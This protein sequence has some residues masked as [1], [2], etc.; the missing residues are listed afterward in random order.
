MINCNPETVSTD[1]DICDRLYFDEISFETVMEIYRLEQPSGIVLSMGGQL[2]NNIAIDL[3][4]QNARILGTSPVSIDKAEN[5]LKF[6]HLLDTIDIKQPPWVN[7]SSVE[8]AKKFCEEEGYPCVI[9]PSYVLSGAAMNVALTSQDLTRCLK[10]AKTVSQEFP[11]VVS[12][13]I[14]DAKEIDVDAICKDGELICMA[15]S[16]H[17]ENAGVHSG[18]A[19]LVCP[20]QDLNRETLI[21]IRKIAEAIGKELNVNGPYNMQLIAKDSQLKVI[22]C[23]LRVSR[24]FPFVSKTLNCDFVAIATRV[25]LGES[26]DSLKAHLADQ[27]LTQNIKALDIN[28][29][30]RVG[31]KVPQ[32]SF[33][34]LSG[35][36]VNLGVEMASTGEVACFGENRYEAYLKAMISTGFRIPIKKKVY[37][38]IGSYKHKQELM[39]SVRTLY[40]MGYE[41]YASLGTADYYNGH[42]IKIQPISSPFEDVEQEGE[43]EANESVVD[44]IADYLARMEFDLIINLPMRIYGGRRVSTLGYRTRRFAVDHSI[45]LISDV[46]CTKLL[47]T[48]LKLV[49]GTPAV[50]P[51]IDCL[52]SRKLIRL[53]GLIDIH[54]HLRVPGAEHKEDFA[55]GTA[56]ALAGGVTLV[57]AMPNTEPAIANESSLELVREIAKKQAKCDY[58]LYLGATPTNAAEL[59]KI[60]S[61]P[62]RNGVLGL[63][64]YLN[65]TFGNLRM[66]KMQDW[67]SHFEN[68]PKDMPLVCHAEGQ[69]TAAVI[70]FAQHYNRSVHI[71]HVAREEEIEIIKEAKETGIKVSCEACPHHLFLC[72]DDKQSIGESKSSVKPELCSKS[73]QDALWRNLNVIDCF[74]TDHAPHTLEEKLNGADAPPGFPGLETMLPLL[75]TAVNQG[76]LTLDEL[77]K[78]LYFNP[79]RI[80]NLPDQPNTY[81]EVDLDKEWKIGE[82]F[83]TYSKAGWT[84]FADRLVK[85]KVRRVVLRGEVA[86]IDGE[87][88]VKP[89]FGQEILMKNEKQINSSLKVKSNVNVFKE[90]AINTDSNKLLELPNGDYLQTLVSLSPNLA[91]S[92]NTNNNRMIDRSTLE[93]RSSSFSFDDRLQQQQQQHQTVTLAAAA[94]AANMLTPV[95][96]TSLNVS[97]SGNYLSV[98]KRK[99]DQLTHDMYNNM[100]SALNYS[101][102]VIDYHS[103]NENAFRQLINKNILNVQPFTRDILRNLF[104]L[105]STYKSYDEKGKAMDH[106]LRGKRIGSLFFE[107]STRTKCSFKAATRALGGQFNGLSLQTSSIS[108][109]ES[110]EDT[111][112]MMSNYNQLLIIRHDEPG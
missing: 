9:R 20:P 65:S 103:K 45:P 27:N 82:S 63:K 64:M 31:V 32:F 90:L 51:H 80:F 25:I 87:V 71:C 58:A 16:E 101:E 52:T 97:Q 109:G 100:L 110:F 15:I 86:F 54:V 24:S 13:F 36:D 66:S 88:L 7:A 106:I 98:T 14:V 95:L 77:I 105:A 33:S 69:T 99:E 35:A 60:V 47:I 44:R 83:K 6:S 92:N 111:V 112:T 73:D 37:L 96:N 19:T 12:K 17:V 81:I 26:F 59:A 3:H 56:A 108:K 62:F 57:C 104:D 22:E 74:A 21:K 67:R 28:N 49:N 43:L 40:N 91:S 39:Y 34:R 79:K 8:Q 94:A 53:P 41:L 46:K 93:L 55:S 11:V 70:W 75:L 48:A 102:R 85:G 4:L 18:D 30:V 1:Y 29:V 107:N 68:W 38:S 84:P 2:P 76:R 5:R 89:G 72:E 42:D 23:N 10:A 50:K 61:K 78:K